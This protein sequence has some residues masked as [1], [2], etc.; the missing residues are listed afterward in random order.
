[1]HFV[2][3]ECNEENNNL[4]KFHHPLHWLY[5]REKGGV[6]HLLQMIGCGKTWQ[7][8]KSIGGLDARSG[9]IN[10]SVTW[11]WDKTVPWCFFFFMAGLIWWWGSVR[12]RGNV[13]ITF[14]VPSPA[15]Q[16]PSHPIFLLLTLTTYTSFTCYTNNPLRVR[17]P[18][19]SQIVKKFFPLR[20]SPVE[21]LFKC[22][23]QFTDDSG[24]VGN[25]EEVLSHLQ[26]L[27]LQEEW[28]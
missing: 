14:H 24:K 21:H 27:I 17:C 26:K 15:L 12:V 1:M 18:K 23:C 6:Y 20:L 16:P 22:R 5:E 11:M 4:A 7:V 9:L 3:K 2:G 19:S 28:C 13:F 8:W 10:N 25:L